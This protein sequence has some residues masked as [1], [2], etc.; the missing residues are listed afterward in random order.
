VAFNNEDMVMG[1]YCM[2]HEEAH[3]QKV[4]P[5]W[6]HN[7]ISMITNVLEGQVTEKQYEKSN[8]TNK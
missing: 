3:S 1:N 7:I 8:E 4:C 5:Y 2:L 6:R